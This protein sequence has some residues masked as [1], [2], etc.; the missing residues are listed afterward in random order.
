M[1]L[2]EDDALIPLYLAHTDG[3][4]WMD[5]HGCNG[6]VVRPGVAFWILSHGTCCL[7]LS[8]SSVR[9]INEKN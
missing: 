6:W 3:S 9:M 8:Y 1:T 4:T 2:L 5:L 7:S